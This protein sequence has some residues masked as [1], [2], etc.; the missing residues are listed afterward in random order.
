MAWQKRQ[1]VEP[2]DIKNLRYLDAAAKKCEE[3]YPQV[4]ELWR[5]V[6][7]EMRKRRF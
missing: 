3:I 6:Q 4:L 1:R 7:E 5:Q 2:E